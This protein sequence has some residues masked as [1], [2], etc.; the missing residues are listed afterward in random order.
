[1]KKE[2]EPKISLITPSGTYYYLRMPEGLKNTR[3]SFS[4][5]TAKVLCS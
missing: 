5:M 2:D 3:G 4:K 1:M